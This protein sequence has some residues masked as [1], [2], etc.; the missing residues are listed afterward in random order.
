MG[1]RQDTRDRI[2]GADHRARPAASGHRGRGRAVAAGDRAR[3]GHGVV[4]G[5]PLRRQP[6]RA[7]DPAA[8]RRLFGAR[9]RGRPGARRGAA[10]SWRDQLL[11]MAHAARG[12][13][14]EQPASW[15]LLYGSPVPGYHAPRERTVGPGTRVVGRCS[16]RSRRA[17]RPA[18]FRRPIVAVAQPLSSDF[19]RLR[20]EFEFSGDDAA[21]AKC[22]LLW[23]GLVGAISLEVFG[24]YGADTFD[25]ARSGVRQPG[26][27][28]D[29]DT[30]RLSDSSRTTLVLRGIDEPRRAA[31]LDRGRRPRS[32]TS[33]EPRA[34]N[35]RHRGIPHRSRRPREIQ[36]LPEPVGLRLTESQGPRT[37][38]QPPTT[39]CA[40]PSRTRWPSTTTPAPGTGSTTSSSPW[41]TS[42]SSGHWPTR[43]RT[44]LA[45][46]DDAA[47][48]LRRVGDTGRRLRSRQDRSRRT[49]TGHRSRVNPERGLLIPNGSG[50]V[51]ECR[52]DLLAVDAADEYWVVRHV[53]VE[54]WQ[55][56]EAVLRDE[57]AIAACWAWEQDYIGMEVAGT[58]HNEVRVGGRLE[59]P[60]R[61]PRA[62]VA[63]GCPARAQRRRPVDPAA[64]AGVGAAG[65]RSSPRTGSKQLT[66][67]VA[68]PHPHPSHPGR[69]STRP[70][71]N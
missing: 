37:R 1:K 32:R 39:G 8:G 58:I 18:T 46:R 63:R 49:R 60:P 23:A 2:E 44:T 67:G 7:A 45:H 12:W 26:R 27:A 30:H 53:I 70:A 54:D 56:Q 47:R 20:E 57:A 5:V 13:A 43:A 6:R 25:R 65:R 41:C 36:T 3:P 51:Y 22:F 38:S 61:P 10:D 69:R 31:G 66:A 21:V 62:H 17:S 29:R 16:T 14:V 52:V 42:H 48:L 4:G 9:R 15:A 34:L 68:A 64:P 55:D 11:A 28:A 71:R 19:D 59:L 40:P 50:V 24:Q 33:L 35:G